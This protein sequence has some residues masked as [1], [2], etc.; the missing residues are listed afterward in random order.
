MGQ[1]LLTNEGDV[2][3][4]QTIQDLASLNCA[5]QLIDAVEITPGYNPRSQYSNATSPFSNG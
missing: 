5:V 4:D 2:L 3:R 1:E